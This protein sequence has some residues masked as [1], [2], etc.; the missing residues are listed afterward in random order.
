[1]D[2]SNYHA[3]FDRGAPRWIEAAWVVCKSLAFLP[4]LPLP[5]A[6]RAALLR[7]FGAK[8]GRGLVIRGGVNIVFPWRLELGDH[9]WIGEEAL[10]LNLAPVTIGSH[11]CI[12]QRSFLCTG[13]HDF[14]SPGF[15]LITRPIVVGAGC[16]IAAQAFVGPGVTIGD[17]T[18]VRAGSVVTRDVPPG[19]VASG[20]PASIKPVRTEAGLQ[21]AGA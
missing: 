21:S 6:L 2:L 20:N 18:M 1:M 11:S 3:N 5:S 17:G 19:S 14:R 9:V 15:D 12:S 8:V 13:S 16:W 10:I 4:R 7:L